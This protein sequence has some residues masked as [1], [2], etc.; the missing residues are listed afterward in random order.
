[1]HFEFSY[2]AMHVYEFLQ[3]VGK[4]KTKT[5]QKMLQ[6]DIIQSVQLTLGKSLNKIELLQMIPVNTK[7]ILLFPC[8]YSDHV[9]C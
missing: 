9:K 8:S 1:V 7:D 2:S 6:L 3:F 5:K 4:S